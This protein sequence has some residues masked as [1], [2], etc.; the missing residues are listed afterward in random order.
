MSAILPQLMER[1]NAQMMP[2]FGPLAIR[3]RYSVRDVAPLN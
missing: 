2:F 3:L 1:V